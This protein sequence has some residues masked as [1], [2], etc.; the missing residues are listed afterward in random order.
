MES[1]TLA[2]RLGRCCGLLVVL[3]VL[4]YVAGEFTGRA[5][6]RLN[7]RLA[8]LWVR[9]WVSTEQPPRQPLAV[10]FTAPSKPIPPVIWP[11]FD[12]ALALH[13]LPVSKIRPI[14]GIRSK[15]HRKSALIAYCLAA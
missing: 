5:V 11:L 9:L 12:D 7:D 3:A 2:G 1:L 4:V 14:A 6:H 13:S 15:A 8:H 10:T